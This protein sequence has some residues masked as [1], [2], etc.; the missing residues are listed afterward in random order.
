MIWRPGSKEREPVRL[1]KPR[2]ASLSEVR[3]TRE[4]TVEE[5]LREPEPDQSW[6]T[7]PLRRA[8][9]C[10]WTVALR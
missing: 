7:N 3:M 5:V 4:K 6:M 9:F 10:D 8:K 2:I 1:K